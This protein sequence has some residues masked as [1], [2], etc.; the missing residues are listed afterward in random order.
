VKHRVNIYK[1]ARQCGVRLKDASEH[2][3]ASRRPGDCFCKPTVREIGLHHG[4]DHLRLVFMLLTGDSGN[5]RQL[6]A[7]VLKAVSRLIVRHPG[8]VRRPTFV[9]DFNAINVHRL[10][11]QARAMN[12]DT[13]M[14]DVLHVLLTLTFIKPANDITSD[15]GEAA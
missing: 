15:L 10:R 13:P 3:P 5:A 8:L 4:E 11:R 2:S 7:D 6:Y 12:C 14:S 9:T 1:V